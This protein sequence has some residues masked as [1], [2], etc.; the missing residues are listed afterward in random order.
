MYFWRKIDYV[1]DNWIDDKNNIP[2]ILVGIRQCG[3]TESVR[4]FAKRHQYNLIEINFWNN[5]DYITDFNGK[6]DVE[7]IISNISLRFPNK[8]FDSNNTLLFF[9][10]IQECPRAR[11]S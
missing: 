3:K 7:T 9:D 6:L 10:E 8:N 4:E 2:L 11:L 1:L 5:S